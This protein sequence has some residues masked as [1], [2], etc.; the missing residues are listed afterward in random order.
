MVNGA[1]RRSKF[2]ENVLYVLGKKRKPV[3]RRQKH[4]PWVEEAAVKTANSRLH[5]LQ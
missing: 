1:S 3:A 4:V 2:S 5:P